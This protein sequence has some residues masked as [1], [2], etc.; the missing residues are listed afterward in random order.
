MFLFHNKLGQPAYANAKNGL[1][2]KNQWLTILNLNEQT[3]N[4]FYLSLNMVK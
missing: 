3:V 2:L 4:L 1:N